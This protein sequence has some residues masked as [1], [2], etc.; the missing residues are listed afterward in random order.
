MPLVYQ[1]LGWLLIIIGLPLT[2]SPIPVGIVIV[3]VGLAL[4]LANSQSARDRLQHIRARHASFDRWMC[5]AERYVPHPF[6]RILKET[7]SDGWQYLRR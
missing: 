1:T 3:A 6:D 2:L 4:I 7:D 5:K